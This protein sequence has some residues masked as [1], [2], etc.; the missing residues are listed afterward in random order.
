MK[1]FN[2][3]SRKKEEFIPQVEGEYKIYVCGPTVYN[4]IHVGNARPVCVFDTLRR[5]LEYKGNKVIFVQNVTDIDDKLIKR[6]NEENKTVK[7]IAEIYENEFVKD[8]KGLNVKTPT[9]QPRATEHID[10][11]LSIIKDI[12]TKGYGYVAKNGDVYFRA[13]KFKEYGKLSH[14]V[15]E[16]LEAGNRNLQSNLED[17]L[18]EDNSDFAVWKAAKEG[19]PY[20]ESPYGKG[21]PGWH[22]EC[23]AMARKHLGTTIDLHCGGQDL[24]FPHHENEIA[25]SECANGC[26]F[27]KYWMHNEFLNINNHKMSKSANN[28]FTVRDVANAYGYEAI[29]Y[30]LIS[31]HYR[32]QLNY[33]ID[34]IEGCNSSL[35]RLYTCIK[36]ID[37]VI[38]NATGTQE[39]LIKL[40]DETRV[41]FCTAMEDDL[42]TPAALASIFEFVKE[43]NTNINSQSKHSLETAK[44]LIIELTQVLG[45]LYNAKEDDIPTN[46]LELAQKRKEARENKDW[47]LADSIRD[48]LKNLGYV[49]EDTKN[50][51]KVVKL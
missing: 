31:G 20:W 35:E 23:S 51:A 17:D 26:T 41:K 8:C 40:A 34:V 7:E 9:V 39:D 15:L 11:I 48:E 29:R 27:S 1:I 30:F 18:K 22:I 43:V 13:K 46:V 45:I 49:I 6:A 12:I 14:L 33:T 2:T 24:I 25:Q 5:Y 44:N 42:N 3:V 32:S 38:N 16:D 36:N 19:E 50:G 47:A 37:F 10:E 28:F 4:F 21:R